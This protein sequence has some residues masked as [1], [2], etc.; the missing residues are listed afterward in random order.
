MASSSRSSKASIPSRPKPQPTKPSANGKAAPAPPP[1]PACTGPA[2]ALDARVIPVDQIRVDPDQ[3]RKVFDQA[4]ILRLAGSLLDR[5]QLQPIRVRIADATD[6]SGGYILLI[7]ERR[8]RA[9]MAAGLPSLTAIIHDGALDPGQI[10]VIQLVQNCCR[11]DL[12]PL[13]Q[14]RAMRSLLEEK[15][16]TQGKLA[17]ELGIS[18]STVSRSLASLE[19]SRGLIDLVTAGELSPAVARELDRLEDKALVA[20]LAEDAVRWSWTRNQAIA[21]ARARGAP[22]PTDQLPFGQ[23]SSATVGDY[24][25]DTPNSL[26]IAPCNLLSDAGAVPIDLST[27]EVDYL[28][29]CNGCSWTKLKS[30]VKALCPNGHRVGFTSDLL[31]VPD[32]TDDDDAEDLDSARDPEDEPD[33]IPSLTSDLDELGDVRTCRVC[34]CTDADCRGCIARTGSPCHWVEAD[35]CSACVPSGPDWKKRLIC[36]DRSVPLEAL[37]AAKELW[38]MT[39]GELDKRFSQGTTK[40]TFQGFGQSLWGALNRAKLDALKETPSDPP[41]PSPDASRGIPGPEG[42]A[43]AST[44]VPPPV[45]PRPKTQA[46]FAFVDH[47]DDEESGFEFTATHPDK[48]RTNGALMAAAARRWAAE[49][50]KRYPQRT[51]L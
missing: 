30:N 20:K 5:G 42:A 9:A 15:N 50:S 31:I 48:T 34:G 46:S 47:Y 7:G 8:W 2:L 28:V 17:D 1:A 4:A 44:H 14:A 38:I 49:L 35:L 43:L 13:D 39:F 19:W 12:G 41:V 27:P 23:T 36:E 25:Q 3:P 32:L 24:G 16:W 29:R 51:T 18:H 10:Q 11:E 26:E 37:E 40:E 33:S 6:P 22:L 21:A 45:S